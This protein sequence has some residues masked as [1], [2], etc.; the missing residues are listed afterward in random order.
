MQLVVGLS[1]FPALK[2]R[3]RAA[4]NDV[5][6]AVI[7]PQS[8]T[9]LYQLPRLVPGSHPEISVAVISYDIQ[10]YNSSDVALAC[11]ATEVVGCQTVADDHLVG[12]NDPLAPQIEGSL[13]IGMITMTNTES[14]LWFWLEDGNSGFLT[15]SLRILSA[16][17][18]PQITSTS[19][20]WWEDDW[21]SIDPECGQFG[22][23]S[24][25]FAALVNTN[26][27][28]VALKGISLIFASG[29]SG[30]NGRTDLGCQIPQLR[31]PFPASSP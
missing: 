10:C 8:V 23:D 14:T 3:N 13:D 1:M 4:R 12:H 25:Q 11:D 19:Y 24:Y 20:A 22:V 21:C 27:A 5:D 31:P 26:F 2:K 29:D 7:V 9:H 30:A 18:A 17:D 16:T 28:K 15:F 6:N